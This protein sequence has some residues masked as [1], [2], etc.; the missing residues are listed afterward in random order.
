MLKRT[1]REKLAAPIPVAGVAEKC[2]YLISSRR[3]NNLLCIALPSPR[4]AVRHPVCRTHRHYIL[5]STRHLPAAAAP[6]VLNSVAAGFGNGRTPGRQAVSGVSTN[7]RRVLVGNRTYR[8]FSPRTLGFLIN[9]CILEIASARFPVYETLNG[10]QSEKKPLGF[11]SD[12]TSPL[13][14]AIAGGIDT[15]ANNYF[16]SGSKRQN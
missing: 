3:R 14:L 4:A 7:P 10:L 16:S 15:I 2:R 8:P 5:T 11:P 6:T 12:V 1:S 13:S 9:L